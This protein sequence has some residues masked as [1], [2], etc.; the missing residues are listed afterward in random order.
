VSCAFFAPLNGRDRIIAGG[1]ESM[2]MVSTPWAG[3]PC[4]T[5]TSQH[6]DY[7]YWHGPHRQ[8]ANDF[9]KSAA[10]TRDEFSIPHQKA[11]KAIEGGKFKKQIKA[12][13][14]WRK[15]T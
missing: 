10:K 3:K 14:L 15:P 13:D 7:A 9:A 11:I 5:T 4:P 6:P 1:T 8:P 12:R 2:S